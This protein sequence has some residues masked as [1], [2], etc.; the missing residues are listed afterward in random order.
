[1]DFATAD[2]T[3]TATNDYVSATGTLT[4]NPGDTSKIISVTIIQDALDETNETFDINLSNSTNS[5][6]SDATGT[7]TITDDEGTPTLTLPM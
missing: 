1:M 3:A 2:G 4:F 7:V 6:I 5:S